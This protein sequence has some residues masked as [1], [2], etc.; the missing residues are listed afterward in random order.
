MED[1]KIPAKDIEKIFKIADFGHDGEINYSEFLAVAVDKRKALQHSNLMFAF[2]HFDTDSS[3]FITPANLRECFKREGKHLTDV[4]IDMMVAEVNPQE[5]GK[6]TL[7]EFEAYMRHL[8]AAEPGSA[9]S[10][11]P[12]IVA[13]PGGTFRKRKNP[14]STDVTRS[15]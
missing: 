4:E 13:A 5:E 3:G 1:A 2:H 12:F 15:E 11:S 14:S 7:E 8:M 9:L 10:A 6:V